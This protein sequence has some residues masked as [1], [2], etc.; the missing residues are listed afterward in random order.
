VASPPPDQQQQAAQAAA[1]VA[2]YQAQTLALR[3][4]LET[5]LRGLWQSLGQYRAPQMASFAKQAV[6]M[7]LGAQQ[8]MAALTSAYLAEQER[9]AIGGTSTPAAAGTAKVTGS[10]ARN[11]ASMQDVYERP[12]HLVWRQLNELPRVQGSIEQAITAGANRAVDLAQTDL[13]LTK[14]RTALQVLG[15]DDRVVGYRRVLEGAHS[16]GLCIVAATQRYHRQTLMPIHPGCD[17]S[18]EPIWSHTDTGQ[19]INPVVRD[20]GKLVP[21]GDLADVHDRIEQRFGASS[22]SA[23]AIPGARDNLGRI[24]QYRDVLITHEHGELGPVL[25]VRGQPFTGPDDLAA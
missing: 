2:L 24:V 16:C 4:Q 9:L 3:T 21:V 8:H 15:P 19:T 6:P 11:G 23:R 5:W 22:S 17:C 18:V 14:T 13:Q 1:V 7:V 12:F 20:G 10:A 25:G